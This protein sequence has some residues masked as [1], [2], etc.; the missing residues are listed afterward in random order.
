MEILEIQEKV[1]NFT[2]EQVK[3]LYF[4]ASR[5]TQETI[6]ELAPILLKICLE[7]ETG[8]LKNEL[9]RVIF[10]LQKTERLNTRLGF[11]KLLHGA[12]RVS[13]EE[14]LKLLESGASDAQDLVGRIKSV[15]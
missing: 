4:F 1:L 14:S 15:L 8:C 5:V 11:E 10:H 13:A 7:D 12:L 9:G 3:T 2:D 6:D